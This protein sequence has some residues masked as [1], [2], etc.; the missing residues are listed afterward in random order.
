MK[1]EE[2]VEERGGKTINII[3]CTLTHWHLCLICKDGRHGRPP[4]QLTLQNTVCLTTR[5]KHTFT[6]YCGLV[7]I[8]FYT[9]LTINI[10]QYMSQGHGFDSQRGHWDFH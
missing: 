2:W 4:C 10:A 6:S 8:I 9:V 7:Y 5:D 1:G 3:F